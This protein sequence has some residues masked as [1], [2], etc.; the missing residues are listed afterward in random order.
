MTLRIRDRKFS[1]TIP[2][3]THFRSLRSPGGAGRSSTKRVLLFHRCRNELHIIEDACGDVTM[4]IDSFLGNDLEL[5]AKDR[6]V[7]G[8]DRQPVR[9]VLKLIMFKD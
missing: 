8:S 3:L 5:A 4:A 6:A 2:T 7:G 9:G 1:A